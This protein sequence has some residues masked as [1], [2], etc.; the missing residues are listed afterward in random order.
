MN[1][2][3]STASKNHSVSVT[4][5]CRGAHPLDRT[6][7]WHFPDLESSFGFPF[8]AMPILTAQ[9]SLI[10]EG[11]TSDRSSDHQDASVS[12]PKQTNTIWK[13][14]RKGNYW[15]HVYHLEQHKTGNKRLTQSSGNTLEEDSQA[16]H[17]DRTAL[18]QDTQLHVT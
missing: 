13:K 14:K 5:P 2:C 9:I 11:L 17:R 4:L 8:H 7:E 18:R 16:D 10:P 12:A 6:T 3:S 15:W 1:K